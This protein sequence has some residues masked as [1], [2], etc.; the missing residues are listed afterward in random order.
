[1]FKRYAIVADAQ[2]LSKALPNTDLSGKAGTPSFP[3]DPEN[4]TYF[5]CRAI[6]ANVPNGNGD[7]F[8]REELKS[9][10][11]S[12]IG[13]GLYKDHN[14]ES[15]DQSIGQV[16]WAEY[17]DDGDYVEC[18]ARV[19]K[20]LDPEMSRRIETGQAGTVSMGCM[21]GEAECSMC[22]NVAHNT[23]ELCEHMRPGSGVK[24]K[25][26]ES[27]SVA[28]EINRMLQFT[29][30]SLVTVPADPTAKIFEVIAKLNSGEISKDAFRSMLREE[31][32]AAVE[33]GKSK[34][35]STTASTGGN[36]TITFDNGTASVGTALP[37]AK[38]NINQAAS[39]AAV[40]NGKVVK[41]PDSME[42]QMDLDI[43]YH[44][45]SSLDNSFFVARER[46]A[47]YKACAAEVLPLVVQEAILKNQPGVSTPEQIIA[48]L[49][50]K[51][52]TLADFRKWA[53]R[54]KKKNKK[55]K[56]K[57]DDKAQDK[58]E[59]EKEEKKEEKKEESSANKNSKVTVESDA[60]TAPV[61][62]APS[63]PPAGS[64]NHPVDQP[65]TIEPTQDEG[66]KADEG[67][68]PDSPS[69]DVAQE[70]DVE[71]LLETLRSNPELMEHLL[72]HTSKDAPVKTATKAESPKDHIDKGTGY[73]DKSG[74]SP[75]AMKEVSKTESPADYVDRGTTKGKV[76][77]MMPKGAEQI[78][79]LLRKAI[80][81]S[82]SMNPKEVEKVAKP[83]KASAG[84]PGSA[85]AWNSKEQS[86]EAVK[87][88]AGG[89][90]GST[91]KKYYNRL[92][93]GGLGEAPK[94]MDLKS[95]VREENSLKKALAESEKKIQM[96]EEKERMSQIVSKIADIVT[97]LQSKNLIAS[98]KE[99]ATIQLLSS[100]F[101]DIEQLEKVFN[102]VKSLKA[103]MAEEAADAP[104]G[105]DVPNAGAVP[106]V[107]ETVEETEDAIS[108]MSKIWNAPTL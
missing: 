52:A 83:G 37:P 25:K 104:E 39:E 11:K 31:I 103:A 26:T 15:V 1:M 73:G 94:A 29:E 20:K 34:S 70:F 27:G 58:K 64:H 106:Q 17:I 16:V 97:H 59:D 84:S 99:D 75:A 53:K 32:R 61:M 51:C 65:G 6:S 102:F 45:G 36:I 55:A 49:A 44:R 98:D 72:S 90:A 7:L 67:H 48:D 18:I 82:W 63:A 60:A 19:D 33:E 42:E 71:Q 41:L 54:R 107:F 38:V 56:S 21:V 80:D 100:S 105:A 96:Y 95:M 3:Y 86:S 69:A 9:S 10:Y 22:H 8:S 88:K 78:L 5:R 108:M 62:D 81:N 92:P 87:P 4:F 14:S 43:K 2:E 89:S 12:F 50:D 35:T 40:S 74:K 77:G 101:S 57:D 30:L 68:L 23:H 79:S 28:H 13:V 46:D 93:S 47:E 91:V 85:V 76:P 24:G 66:E